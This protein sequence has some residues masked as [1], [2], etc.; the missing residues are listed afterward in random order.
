MDYN[1]VGVNLLT[2]LGKDLVG[3]YLQVSDSG[4]EKE[5]AY[6]LIKGR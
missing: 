2:Q 3:G 5:L 6:H 4:S 1:L